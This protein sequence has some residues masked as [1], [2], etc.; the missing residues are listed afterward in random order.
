MIYILKCE[1]P[2]KRECEYYLDINSIKEGPFDTAIFYVRLKNQI[3]YLVQG[4]IHFYFSYNENTQ[5]SI[6]NW[7]GECNVSFDTSKTIKKTVQ[8]K[9]I[10]QLTETSSSKFLS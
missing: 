2:D 10:Y 5:L 6:T 4:G 1:S 7:R 9:I 3:D 8:N